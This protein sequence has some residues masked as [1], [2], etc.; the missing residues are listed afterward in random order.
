MLVR[1]V[2]NSC[3]QVIHL[4]GPLKVLG[5]QAWATVLN[6]SNKF[7]KLRIVLIKGE[8]GVHGP[9]LPFIYLVFET[10]SL[11]LSPRLERSGTITAHSSL[12]LS[13]SSYPRCTPQPSPPPP[14]ELLLNSW[15]QAVL[16]PQP[17]KVLGLQK[18]SRA[19]HGGSC[20]PSQHFERPKQEDGLRPGIRD[21]HGQHSE[22]PLSTKNKKFPGLDASCSVTQCSDKIS[23]HRSLNLLGS[24][25]PPSTVSQVA[26][27][28][29]QKISRTWWCVPVVPA[30]RE[31]E[32]GE[33]L[34]TGKRKLHW[35]F[36]LSPKLECSDMISAHCNLCL[37]GS[38]VSASQIAGTTGSCHHAWLISFVFV[39]ETGFPHIGQTGLELLT[40]QGL[41]L[42]PRLECSGVISAL[43]HCS[44]DLPGSIN[45]PASASQ[46][47]WTTALS[48]RQSAVAR[49]QLTAAL[50]SQAQLF[51]HFGLLSSW[52]YR[53]D[54]IL[55]P[56][57]SAISAHYNLC[58]L[59]QAI[60]LPQPHERGFTL[61]L[62]VEYSG[63]ISDHC[64]LNL[65]ASGDPS[66]LAS[67]IAGQQAHATQ[68]IFRGGFSMLP[69]LVSN[70][71]AQTICSPWLPKVLGLQS[72]M[73]K[74]KGICGYEASR[75]SGSKNQLDGS[76]T[77]SPRLEYSGVILGHC[78]L[79][80]LGSRFHHV[81][82]AG[83]E[84][85]TSGDLPA[86]ASQSAEIT[87]VSHHA[88]PKT[89]SHFVAQ[90]G[91]KLMGSSR[92]PI[93]ASQNARITGKPLT[94]EGF[95]KVQLVR[96]IGFCHVGQA[97]LEFLAS[98]D[99]PTL[100]SQSAGL[101]LLPRLESSGAIIAYCRHTLLGSS[102]PPTQPPKYLK[103]Q[104]CAIT[105]AK[106]FYFLFLAETRSHFVVQYGL[107]ILSSSSPLMLT[108]QSAGITDVFSCW[109]A[110]L[111]CSGA[112]TAHCSSS[113]T[114]PGS[115]DPLT[116]ASRVAGT[117]GT[118]HHP[119]LLFKN[120]FCKDGVSP[121]C[122]GWSQTSGLKQSTHLSF[123]KQFCW[124]PRLEC[125]GAILA[126][127]NFRLLSSKTGIH[128]VG[129]AGLKLLTS[130]DLP[131]WPPKVLG[132]QA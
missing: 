114:L 14:P 58:L 104:V 75:P 42:S 30:T 29:V 22:N 107:K 33:L 51:S 12:Y 88:R 10:G 115:S 32:A 41:T 4:P 23:A 31:A 96:E 127:C 100:V 37:P 60:L 131:P 68:L 36:S 82:Q 126:H 119:Q 108:F 64:S 66:T 128:H 54:L 9:P 102:D 86:S 61:L 67:Q 69:R 70:C 63:T 2:W 56:R 43:A 110:R 122:P 28:T 45:S 85:L 55:S 124:S 16:P 118:C 5:L 40:L 21:H 129:Q 81:G 19:G 76:P 94:H 97:G 83:H 38:P 130:G 116:S 109:L 87:G 92:S 57:V 80:L 72:M 121:R 50:T 53:W 49:S 24:S 34:E 98:S 77:L 112:I 120:I 113:L 25:E 46:V 20:L 73:E 65:F 101:A 95:S 132:L 8:E 103:L 106:F 111:E 3:P 125:D 89:G 11:T 71:R 84:L 99:L 39:V 52:D 17:P 44:L 62:R 18:N 79:C 15:S 47:A 117:T 27:T 7:L 105:L 91:L 90:S 93:S 59:V 6:L 35:S 13:G 123:P 26:G 78:N 74:E 48:P 1:L